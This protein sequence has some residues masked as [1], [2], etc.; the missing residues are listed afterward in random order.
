MEIEEA[1][2]IQQQDNTA[3]I[4]RQPHHQ[5]PVM[6][7]HLDSSEI[8]TKLKNMLLGLE[9]N[10]EEDEW[11]ETMMIIGYGKDN[12]PIYV[13]EGPLMEPRDIRITIGY[14]Q[15]FLNANT[16]LSKLTEE[17]INDIMWDIN[18]KLAIMFYN[19]RHKIN[20]NTRDMIWGMIEYPILLGLS[21]ADKKITLDAMSKMQHSIEHI[22][23]GQGTEQQPKTTNK[24]FKILGW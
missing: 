9:Y 12:K 19:L 13:A 7:Q 3:Y 20:P 4:S 5:D 6:S 23:A 8:L 2:A 10:E 16:F 11:E 24:E 15:M 17:R 18:K 14:L 21:R 22:R 1:D